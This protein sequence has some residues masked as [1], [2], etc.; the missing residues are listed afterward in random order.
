MWAFRNRLLI[1]NNRLTE[2]YES[3]Q[4]LI[5]FCRSKGFVKAALLNEQ[6]NIVKIQLLCGN[7][8]DALIVI[9]TV[10]AAAE[11]YGLTDEYLKACSLKAGIHLEVSSASYPL[12]ILKKIEESGELDNI[13]VDCQSLFYETKARVLEKIAAILAAEG[14]YSPLCRS[15]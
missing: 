2:A 6:L 1:N 3:C 4:R 9:E 8:F 11:Q 14:M 13:S 10:I 12:H 7:Y 5:S 15:S